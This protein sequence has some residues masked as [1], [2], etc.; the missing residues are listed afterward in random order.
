MFKPPDAPPPKAATHV[1]QKPVPQT[2]ARRQRVVQQPPALPLAAEQPAGQR[3]R[4]SA[5]VAQMR[6]VEP[7]AA[8][9]P[10]ESVSAPQ[11]PVVERPVAQ[12]QPVSV[13][14]WRMPAVRRPA[15]W[16]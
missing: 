5:C 1:V 11:T 6:A 3:H 7:P 4:A 9:P 8:E 15:R 16:I 12:Q 2:L 10:P 13:D 14:A